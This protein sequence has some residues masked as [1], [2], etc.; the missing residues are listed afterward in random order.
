MKVDNAL[1][2]AAGTSSRFAPLSYEKP[3]SLIK[4]KGE[5]LLE[6]QIRQLKEAGIT[7][8]FIVTGYKA[9]DFAYLKEKFNVKF[10]YNPDYLTRNNNGSIWVA[11][12]I[13]KNTYICSS[14]NYFA[15]NPFETDVAECYYAAEY[16]SG[17]TAEWCMQEDAEGNISAVTLGGELAWYM[18]GHAFWSETFSKEF[19]NILQ[20]EYNLPETKDK[21][22]EKIFMAHLDVLKMKIRK[23]P[24]N[25]IFEFDTMDELREFDS[26]YKINTR[27]AIMKKIANELN[28]EESEMVHLAAIKCVNNEAIGF[29]FECPKGYFTY[30]YENGKLQKAN[31]NY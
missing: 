1:I 7:E 4:V 16:A 3:K 12:D 14:D 15:V 9:E 8:I 19:L 13:I 26:S 2:M 11:K 17:H 21:L 10:I 22:W 31:I 27:S 24:P 20:K 6:R 28:I 29:S 18:L 5:I 23:Y 30:Y 25:V